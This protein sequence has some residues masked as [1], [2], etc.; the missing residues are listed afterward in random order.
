MRPVALRQ[1]GPPLHAYWSTS[2]NVDR[3]EMTSMSKLLVAVAGVT[4]VLVVLASASL[5][6]TP[7][8]SGTVGPGFT[9][10]LTQGGKKVKNLK[11]G[12]YMF[13]IN[14]R[15]SMHSY[16]LDGPKGFAKDFTSV[17]FKG[18]KT[19]TVQLKVGKYKYYCTPHE[20]TMFGNF[21]VS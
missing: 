5:A 19:F 2:L 12:T 6:S 9:I 18:T 11:A 13:V 14:D 17:S 20:S 15:S 3:M 10:T 1:S 8:L 21:T 16:G 7:K 4:V